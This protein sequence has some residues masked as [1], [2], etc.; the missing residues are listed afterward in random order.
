MPST[1]HSDIFENLQIS[2]LSQ[3]ME[4]NI[5]ACATIIDDYHLF[6]VGGGPKSKAFIVDPLNASYEFSSAL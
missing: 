1:S 5:S 6:V 4:Q 3:D 2:L